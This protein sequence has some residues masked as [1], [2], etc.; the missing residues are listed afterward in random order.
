MTFFVCVP[1][2]S[3]KQR[4]RS[5]L[6]MTAGQ[7]TISGLIGELTVISLSFLLLQVFRTITFK[8]LHDSNI[9]YSDAAV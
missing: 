3:Q 4:Q 5:G 2:F 7:R 1:Q 8:Y 6:K 9:V